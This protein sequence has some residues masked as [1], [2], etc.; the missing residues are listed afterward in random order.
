MKMIHLPLHSLVLDGYDSLPCWSFYVAFNLAGDSL[1]QSGLHQPV[2]DLCLYDACSD[3]VFCEQTSQ[4]SSHTRASARNSRPSRGR[5]LQRRMSRPSWGLPVLVTLQLVE[6]I[7]IQESLFHWHILIQMCQCLYLPVITW[8]VICR[9][10]PTNVS[11]YS[12][13]TVSCSFIG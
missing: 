1:V 7:Y 6:Y 10:I 4:G 12:Q 5:A 11:S 8:Y 3:S 2:P 9:D 13:V